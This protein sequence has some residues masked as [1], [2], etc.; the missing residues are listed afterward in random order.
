MAVVLS[1]QLSTMENDTYQDGTTWAPGTVRL[2]D[3]K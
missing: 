2:E 3:S 1:I